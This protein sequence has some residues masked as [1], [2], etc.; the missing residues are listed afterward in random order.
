MSDDEDITQQAQFQI[1]IALNLRTA[2]TLPDDLL[3]LLLDANENPTLETI[4][5]LHRMNEGAL[6]CLR[7]RVGLPEQSRPDFQ[8][9]QFLN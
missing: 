8:G 4:D 3:R 1:D 2:A 9:R 6:A 5:R 7:R